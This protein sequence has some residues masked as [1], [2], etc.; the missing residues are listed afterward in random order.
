MELAVILMLNLTTIL[1]ITTLHDKTSSWSVVVSEVKIPQGN[2]NKLQ[3]SSLILKCLLDRDLL[4]FYL[5][6][7][8]HP[9]IQE[10]K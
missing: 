9:Y 6:Q 8:T 7:D 1:N 10:Q 4:L 3:L 5:T 2:N